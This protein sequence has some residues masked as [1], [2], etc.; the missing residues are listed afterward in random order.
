MNAVDHPHGGG[1]HEHVGRPSCVGRY[2]TVGDK[3]KYKF[4]IKYK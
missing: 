4:N 1:F 2:R 3:V